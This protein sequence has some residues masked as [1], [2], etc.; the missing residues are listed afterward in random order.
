MSAIGLPPFPSF[1]VREDPSTAGTRWKRY[2]SKLNNLLSAL[3]I[4]NPERKKALLLHY[5][6]DEL[7][8][9]SETFTDEQNSNYD[10]LT[11]AFSAYFSPSTN[12]TFETFK[13]R[14]LVQDTEETVDQ[15][16]VRLR[17]QAS[18]CNFS[19]VDREILSQLVEGVKSNKLRRK[20]LRDKLSLVAFLTEARNEETIQRQAQEI[21]EQHQNEKCNKVVGFKQQP[22][23]FR[24]KKYLPKPK[25]S[26]PGS[27]PQSGQNIQRCRNCN[28]SWPHPGGQKNCP[29]Y[30]KRCNLCQKLNHFASVCKSSASGGTPNTSKKQFVSVLN[31]EDSDSSNE[32]T[33]DSDFVFFAKNA[34]IDCKLPHFPIIINDLHVNALADSGASVNLLSIANFNKLNVKPKLEKCKAKIFAFG[35]SSPIEIL[36]KF[37]C[38]VKANDNVCSTEFI[39]S[40][41][42]DITI[43]S[44]ETSQKLGLLTTAHNI[45]TKTNTTTTHTTPK[46]ALTYDKAEL[47]KQYPKLFTGVGKLKNVK[48][49]LHIDKDVQPVAQ[50]HR[51]IPFHVRKQLKEQIERDLKNDVIEKADGPT[52]WVSPLVIVPKKQPGAVRVC[53]DMRRPNEAI[54]RERHSTPTLSELSTMLNGATKFSKLDLNQGYN[55]LE[56]DKESRYITTFSTS[57]GLFRYKRLNFG[58]NSA[59]EIFQ[60]TIRQVLSPLKGTVNISD[61]ILVYGKSDE[62]HD[63][64]LRDTL[65]HLQKN[66]CTLNLDKCELGRSEVEFYGHIFSKEGMQPSP[67]KIEEI[68]NLPTPENASEVRSLLGMLNFCGSR[69]IK[70]YA[71]LTYPLRILTQKD[72][73]FSWKEEQEKAFSQLKTALQDDLKLAYFDTQKEPH[74]FVDASPVGLGAILA[75]QDGD[76]QFK[77]VQIGSRSLTPVEQRYSQ[78][79]REA[80]AITWACEYLH[81]YLYGTHFKM[82]TDHQALLAIYGNPKAQLPLRIERWV[83]R[84]QTYDMEILHQVGADNPADYLSRHP[85]AINK[86]SSREEKIAEE[87]VNYI[88][89]TSLPKSMTLDTVLEETKKDK[90]LSVITDAILSGN[91]SSAKANTEEDCDKKTIQIMF[92]CR[93]ELSVSAEGVVL[94]GK[95]IVLPKSLHTTAVK[96]AHTGHQGI[97]KTLGLL[98][99]KVW[100]RGMNNLVEIEVKSCHIC[101]IANTD[102]QRE[103]LKMS[104]LPPHAW[105]EV[106]ADFG[107]APDGS[108]KKIFVITDE[109][110]RY[111]IVEVI[112]N[113]KAS[114][115]ISVLDKVF[116]QHGIPSKRFKTDNGPPFQSHD[117][118]RYMKHIGAKHRKITPLWP[119]AN[120][121]TERFMRIL[122]KSLKAAN[123]LGQ[124]WMQEMNRVLLAYRATPLCTGFSPAILFFGREIKTMLPEKEINQDK[125]QSNS[126]IDEKARINDHK[127]KLEMKKYHDK[128]RNVK[129]EN[130]EI[131]DTVFI[132]DTSISRKKP[133]FEP[134]PLVITDKNHSMITAKRGQRTITRNSSFFKKAINQSV[135][136]DLEEEE[137][138]ESDHAITQTPLTQSDIPN[139][140]LQTPDIQNTNIHVPHTHAPP[141]ANNQ[142]IA[143]ERPVR[144]KKTPAK[145]KD[146]IRI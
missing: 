69:F 20:C 124:N 49:K 144:I 63:N 85:S 29:A 74:V 50:K 55:Q 132:K 114:T 86:Q 111:P 6:G 95:Q 82:H 2:L 143:T 80:L 122:K 126:A 14:K 139:Q 134:D 53:V 52:P 13:F 105:S 10:T 41:S 112:N 133:H 100:F 135:N 21:E 57:E 136:P 48:I 102:T 26:K 47:K 33:S 9:L 115:I 32:Q 71:T 43:L 89:Q 36:G 37:H 125:D 113:L 123:A 65:H 31:E 64:R 101:Q 138:D 58:V 45:Q 94:K 142:N 39:V 44:W 118:K 42:K 23:R 3:N 12:F 38:N 128:N 73:Q 75:Q 83:M 88:V 70:N 27:K 79:E 17:R 91:W 81:I 97:V 110:S 72:V 116:S 141:T 68:L 84:V 108:E 1:P 145:F 16:H 40:N 146:F 67:S 87:Y 90:T 28:G 19:D 60:D 109:Y 131:G 137:L 103:P 11:A 99:Q 62:E 76:K 127:A 8:D 117:F 4:D 18:L 15:F 46:H 30:G 56:L 24:K 107:D 121:E 5:G 130:L 22:N 104:P 119:K 77:T 120:A 7:F 98:R 140:P 78:T 106:S 129:E 54:K 35:S 34:K 66:N 51:R 96:L 25:P 93:K 59:A 92:Q 61:D